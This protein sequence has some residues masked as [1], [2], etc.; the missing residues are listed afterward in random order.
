V[1]YCK[2]INSQLFTKLDRFFDQFNSA[3]L[4]KKG[5][6]ILRAD[7]NP[8]GVY[9]LKKGFVRLYAISREGQEITFNIFKPGSYF[10]M[11][12]AIAN[13]TNHHFFEAMTAVELQRAPK[14]KL[15]EFIKSQPDVLFE[16]TRRILIGLSG[17]ITEMEYLLF[18]N[19]NIKVASVI[20]LLAKR[21]GQKK[22][23]GG[24]VIQHPF[25]HRMIASIAGLTRE[26]TT[27][28]IQKLKQ[29]KVLTQKQH[30]LVVRNIKKLE[31]KL[32]IF[33]EEESVPD[34]F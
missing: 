26:T 13:T 16:L 25:T 9:Y 7:D 20:L 14:E 8:S 33:K 32:A 17:L 6:I 24:V 15:L 21:F 22:T 29:E 4:Y 23:N 18:G 19:A 5:E 28:E 11:M 2:I 10:S 1:L 12:W 3:H 31:E 34:T 27:L 30:L